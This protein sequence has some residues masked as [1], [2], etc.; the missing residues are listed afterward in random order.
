MD[1]LP[2]GDQYGLTVPI[3][4]GHT[5]AMTKQQEATESVAMLLTPQQAAARLSVTTRTLTRMVDRGDLQVVYLSSGHRRYQ[6]AEIA[7][8]AKPQPRE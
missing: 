6:E 1:K 4:H 7:R 5:V 3:C 2:F 8:L